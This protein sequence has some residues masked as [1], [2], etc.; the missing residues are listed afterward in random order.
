M[1]TVV[2]QCREWKPGAQVTLA[3]TCANIQRGV[4]GHNHNVVRVGG[5]T[6]TPN[7]TSTRDIEK[8]SYLTSKQ[9]WSGKKHQKIVIK[10]P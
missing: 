10:F 4:G 9:I 3:I 8:G 6:Y 5:G 1:V 2:T 7:M